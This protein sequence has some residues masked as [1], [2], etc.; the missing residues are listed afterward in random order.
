MSLAEEM[1]Q[2]VS[3]LEKEL[4]LTKDQRDRAMSALQETEQKLQD[5]QKDPKKAEQRIAQLQALASTRLTEKQ[6]LE[7]QV[8]HIT[9]QFRNLKTDVASLKKTAEAQDLVILRL[10]QENAVKDGELKLLRVPRETLNE[11]HQA[12]LTALRRNCDYVIEVKD[13]DHQ[14]EIQNITTHFEKLMEL[15]SKNRSIEIEELQAQ[16]KQK[17]E[18]IKELEGRK[19]YQCKF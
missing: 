8:K 15:Q 10:S 13:R 7:D 6:V 11:E 3:A 9:I 12:D 17:D 4:V 1:V 2:S 5:A 14:T 18:R 16:L 19:W